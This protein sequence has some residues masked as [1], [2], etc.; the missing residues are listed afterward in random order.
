MNRGKGIHFNQESVGVS[1]RK[2]QLPYNEILL[3]EFSQMSTLEQ[4]FTNFIRPVLGGAMCR[5]GTN[6]VETSERNVSCYKI[7]KEL[8]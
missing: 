6:N 7:I 8:I 3:H 4:I 1:F 2:V 5:I